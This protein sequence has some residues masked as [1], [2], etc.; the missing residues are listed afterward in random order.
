M[1]GET[2]GPEAI[3]ARALHR[4]RHIALRGHSYER[5]PL[6]LPWPRVTIPDRISGAV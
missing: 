6:T 2:F 1:I 5:A 4:G 3:L